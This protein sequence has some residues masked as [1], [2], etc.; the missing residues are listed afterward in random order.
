MRLLRKGFVLYPGSFRLKTGPHI[1]TRSW[2]GV[3]K[4]RVYCRR[5]EIGGSLYEV[6]R[7]QN[8]H[9]FLVTTARHADNSHKSLTFQQPFPGSFI[10]PP[11]GERK[12]RDP[13]NEVDFVCKFEWKNGKLFLFI[14]E[15]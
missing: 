3:N 4:Y 11:H 5:C 12:K 10:S 9:V 2:T 14:E 15:I 6:C 7:V 1:N 13:G 8:C